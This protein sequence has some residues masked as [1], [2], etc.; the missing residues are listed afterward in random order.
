MFNTFNMGVGMS[1]V[2]PKEQAEKAVEIL[3]ANGEN[4]YIKDNSITYYYVKWLKEE[5][6]ARIAY[7]ENGKYVTDAEGYILDKEGN[8]IFKEER[9]EKGPNGETTYLHRFDNYGSSLKVE[10][11]YEGGWVK[12]LNGKDGFK[13][14]TVMT[15]NGRD[16]VLG[17][18][19]ELPD[20]SGDAITAGKVELAPMTCTFLVI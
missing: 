1:V 10:G 8:R 5:D 7:D 20:L 19:W 12:E 3:N 6:K 14:A 11:W 13:R 16:L 2:V 18:N 4:A 9:T 17:E 15:L